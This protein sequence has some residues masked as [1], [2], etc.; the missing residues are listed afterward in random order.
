[1]NPSFDRLRNRTVAF[2]H[3]LLMVPVAWLL[4]YWLRFNLGVIP[5]AF[6]EGALLALP[7][8]MLCQGLANSLFGLYRGV[9]RFASLPDLMRILQAVLAGTALTFFALFI[10]NR[11]ESV[12][13]SVLPLYLVL[14]VLLLGGPRL[15]Y[16]WLK[17]HRLSLGTGERVLIVG[18]GQAGEML[19]RD[20]LRDPHLG[21]LPVAFVDDKP[22]RQGAEI[23]GI[24]VR[25]PTEAIPVLVR[26]LEVDLILLA[27]PSASGAQMQCLVALC[28]QSGRPFRTV[29]QLQELMRGQVS[30]NQI[31]PVSIEDL[32]GRN[33]V[34][35]DWAGIRQG[36]VGRVVLV[37]GGGG[38]IGAELCR[39]I[40]LAGP[41]RL[42]IVDNGEYN[43]YRIDAELAERHPGLARDC[44]LL[45]V[46]DATAVEG[47]FRRE[48]PQIV[49]HAA[50]YKHVPLL[51]GQVRAAMRNNLLGT[52]LVARAADAFGCERFVLI[53]TDKAVN[54]TSL[55]GA[56][57]RA[58]EV[59][60]QALATRS[61]TCFTAV[62]F[63]NVLDSAGSVVPLFRRQIERGGPVTL[64]DPQ[65]ERFFMTIPESC[66]LIM[67][68]AVIGAGGEIFV[69]DMGEPVNI[70]YLA[71]QMILL[72]GRR[73]GADIAIEYI[74]LRPGEK[75]REEL[76]YAAEDLLETVHP[77]I[78]I[79][80][81]GTQPSWR[82][83]EPR[84]DACA[85]AVESGDDARLP[86][87]LLDLIDEHGGWSPAE[88]GYPTVLEAVH[89]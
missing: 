86:G 35:L 55:M 61:Q 42:L 3:D 24:P 67:Q 43:L 30:V 17:D 72:S 14:Q 4:A 26:D 88:A 25:G 2:L 16:R 59:I 52:A 76:F 10:F 79:A 87:L 20:M 1:M 85:A 38:S 58:A 12:P 47:L 11:M 34:E 69:L 78:R 41:A 84:L 27:I 70:R 15:I 28:E 40:A 21:Y 81:S 68:A 66:Q 50:A 8:V 75:L 31:R 89:G 13:R 57:K 54:P 36:L 64:T 23:H 19:A 45:D 82:Q 46:T 53:S 18:A 22:R 9:W 56:T 80:R 44:R 51:E 63:G 74:G 77:K 6:F 83:V 65:M 5:P 49:F 29:P 73:P 32:L 37:T 7:L 71:E 33:P 39:Q 60:C 48:R 62:R